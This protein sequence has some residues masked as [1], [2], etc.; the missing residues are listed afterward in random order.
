MNTSTAIA[1]LEN[2]LLTQGHA[3][4][5]DASV[6]VIVPVRNEENAIG[7]VLDQ[8]LRQQRDGLKLEILVVDGRS[9]DK[10]R[11]IVAQYVA[12][13]PEIRL[14]DNPKRLSSAGRNIAIRESHGDYLVVIDGHC[15]LPTRMYFHDLVDAFERSGA[16]CLGRP[17]PLDVSNATTLQ[18][19]IAAARSSPLGHHP[20]SFIYTNEEV[21]C[22]AGSVAVAYKRTVFESVGFFDEEFDACEDYELNHRIDK[23]G[24]RCRLIPKLT[25]KYEPRKKLIGLFRQLFRYG[26]GRVRMSR[27]HRGTINWRT[28]VPAALV[29]GAV[30]GPPL[31]AALPL[32]WPYYFAVM[33]IY[34]GATFAEAIRLA[35]ALKDW[36]LLA[37]LPV[38]FWTI[39]FGSGCGLL[40][41]M[42]A[43]GRQV[44]SL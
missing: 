31:C 2:G 37:W 27:K 6:T 23:A 17:Q 26:R 22:P 43:V 44:K 20:D 40:R 9:T 1:D 13:H 7:H 30:A 16:E 18:Q 5:P 14:L 21:E 8:L 33:G 29:L 12:R 39:H 32:L 41:E 42:A 38:V 34:F 10:T 3:L 19:A 24:L 36:R 11:E 25:V 15:E 35:H 28:L 4:K